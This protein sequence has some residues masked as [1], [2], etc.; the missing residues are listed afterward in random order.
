MI[1]DAGSNGEKT[2]KIRRMPAFAL[3]LFFAILLFALPAQ[4]ADS[5]ISMEILYGYDN[6]AKGGR[7]LPVRISV[8]SEAERDISATLMIQSLE[9][10]GSVYQYDFPVTLEAGGLSRLKEYI[11]LGT[12]T[13][14]LYVC[15]LDESG[16]VLTN[17]VVNLNVSW[18]VP[19]LFIGILSDNPN[20]L[21]FLDGVGID[22]GLMRTRTFELVEEDISTDEEELDQLDVLVVNDYRLSAMSDGKISSIMTWVYNGGVL[23]I[24]TGARVDDTLGILSDELL[25]SPYDSPSLYHIDLSESYPMENQ[26]AGMLAVMCVNLSLHGGNIVIS[27]DNLGLLSVANKERGLIG[28]SAFDLSE[29]TQFCESEPAYVDFFLT[30][31]IGED[32]IRDLAQVVYSGNSDYYTSIQALIN[33]GNVEKLPNLTL[34]V[35]L[36]V[37]YLLILGPGMYLFLRHRNLQNYYRRGVLILAFV[38]VVIIYLVGSATRFRS[39]FYTYA[40]ILD[41]MDGYVTDTTYVNIRN[42]YN[43]TFEVSLDPDYAVL[44]ITRSQRNMPW[45]NTGI[46]VEDDYQI[47]IEQLL[48]RTLL[49]AQNVAAFSPRYFELK[50]RNSNEEGEGISGE[51]SYFDGV[52]TGWIK[53]DYSYTLENIAVILYGNLVTIENIEPGEIKELD[54]LTVLSFP[55]NASQIVAEYITGQSSFA[56]SDIGNTEYLRA[57]K[58]AA[59]LQFYMDNYMMGYT[60]D[61]KI[62]AFSQ[63]KEDTSFLVQ[64]EGDTYGITMLTS[65]LSVASSRNGQVY[66]SV[67]MK[68][69][70]VVT[71][72]YNARN[73]T[74]NGALP[75]TLEY[76]LGTDLLVEDLTF[77]SVSDAFT[78]IGDERDQATIFS[79]SMYLY[80]HIT[81]SYDKLDTVD[82]VL[83]TE[84]LRPYL[85][86]GNILTV[87]YIYEGTG[88]LREIELPM[89]M[90]TGR[91]F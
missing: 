29:L 59:M 60:A 42:P 71:G 36:I 73:N 80:N 9:S 79:G 86:P 43:R 12:R 72:E 82:A 19:E 47:R 11:P 8:N 55:L 90:V 51:I 40:T 56:Y 17:E 75:L 62:I 87:R 1:H 33:T 54:D 50:K 26:D 58:R 53:N 83:S 20:D 28:V 52:I 25:D 67:L 81:G 24:G 45:Q 37:I 46:T 77:R 44:P 30:S 41:S 88:S 22:Y 84:D 21:T 35:I 69:P 13:T 78:G 16:A 74:M 63:E 70:V 15:L 89:P 39:T 85:S 32:R 10:D 76:Q 64:S 3:I 91:S 61:A 31:L 49:T 7:Y 27:S 23:L 66:R 65:S 6:A 14:Q 4:A 38:F 68:T 34:Y 5:A 18:D 48:D 2:A 57:M